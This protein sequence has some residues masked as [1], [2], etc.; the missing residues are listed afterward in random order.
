MARHTFANRTFFI[1]FMIAFLISCTGG[2][3]KEEQI[4]SSAAHIPTWE[5][6][7]KHQTPEWFLDAK[8]GI[9]FHWGPYSVPA[10]KTEWYSHYMYVK[11]HPIQQ[12]HIDKYGPLSEFGYKDFIPDFTAKSFNAEEWVSLFEKA[13]AQFVGPVTEHADG[14]AMWD[15]KLTEWDAKDMGPKRDIVGELEK[16]V[17]KTDMKF[18]T[19]FH[20]QWLWS[21]YSTW[22]ESTDAS[23]PQYEDLYG[24]QLD[25][26]E[27]IGA[28]VNP[29]FMAHEKFAQRWITRLKEV[30]DN[31]N[32]DLIYF[33]NK[34]NI[35]E[36]KHRLDFL[37]YYYNH[38]AQPK[39][40]CRCDLQRQRPSGWCRRPG[41]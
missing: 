40:G 9:Y 12:Y 3:E 11:D 5:S 34:M 21:W 25:S 17:R 4:D 38:A 13:G 30:I 37:Q 10:H 29:T 16:A 33:D 36:E 22:D 2:Q 6:V 41:P 27:F 18:I 20:H 1:S 8:F 23:N 28:E 39:S 7:I 15:S 19:T 26:S 24:P 32:P 31:Y 14:F 35:I